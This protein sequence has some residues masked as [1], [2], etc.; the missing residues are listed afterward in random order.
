VTSTALLLHRPY[1]IEH[2]YATSLD[3]R[4]PVLP[5]TG[6]PVLLGIQALADLESVTCEWVSADGDA[7]TLV[8]PR[9]RRRLGRTDPAR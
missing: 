1:G 7:T 8:L 2:P 9:W 6:E 5:Q 3:Q 4:I